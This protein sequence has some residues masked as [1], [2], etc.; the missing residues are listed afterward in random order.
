MSS[1]ERSVHEYLRR[2]ARDYCGGD[3]TEA[4]THAIVREVIAEKS[5]PKA[6]I[7]HVSVLQ[8]LDERGMNGGAVVLV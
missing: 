3:V 6:D 1:K 2:Y 5:K 4:K 8:Y 7:K